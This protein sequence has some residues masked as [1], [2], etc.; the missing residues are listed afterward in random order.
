MCKT[1]KQTVLFVLLIIERLSKYWSKATAKWDYGLPAC[2]F[3]C[4]HTGPS[5]TLRRAVY[6]YVEIKKLNRMCY[7]SYLQQT[8]EKNSAKEGWTWILGV[9]DM[10]NQFL[11]FVHQNS[12]IHNLVWQINSFLTRFLF[13]Y[14][15]WCTVNGQMQVITKGLIL[16]MC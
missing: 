8:L 15:Q 14:S 1:P 12:H 7:I 10:P 11:P 9:Q 5:L 6:I 3:A 2:L 13:P 16:L 4:A